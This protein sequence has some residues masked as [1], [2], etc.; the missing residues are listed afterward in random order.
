MKRNLFLFVS[1]FIWSAGF[2]QQDTTEVLKAVKALMYALVEKDS[3]VL[4]KLIHADIAFGH[5]N[6][7]VQTK[8]EVLKDMKS[9]Y[10]V[11]QQIDDQST[12]ITI[13]K[14][15]ATVKERI[16]VKGVRDGNSFALNLFVLHW[17]VKTKSGWQLLSRQSTKL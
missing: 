2:S 11:Y 7:W 16:A 14:S 1:L 3:S 8:K 17:W 6:G 10:L 13:S 9:G 4:K 15:Y 5:S 12:A